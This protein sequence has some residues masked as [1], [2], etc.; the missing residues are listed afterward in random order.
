[1]KEIVDY[2]VDCMKEQT[3]RKFVEDDTMLYNG[4]SVPFVNTGFLC[5]CCGATMTLPEDYDLQMKEIRETYN[6]MYRG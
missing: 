3:F 5:L 2:C 4:I 6:H 1:M